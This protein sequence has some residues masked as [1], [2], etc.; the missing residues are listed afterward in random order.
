MKPGTQTLVN[1]LEDGL[2]KPGRWLP[3]HPVVGKIERGELTRTQIAGLMGQ[4]YLQTAEVVRWLGAMAWVD[5][6][7]Q[8]AT[9]M[10]I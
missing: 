6:L 9:S 10:L 1:E 4:I 8:P 2:K 7:L 3:D 5:A